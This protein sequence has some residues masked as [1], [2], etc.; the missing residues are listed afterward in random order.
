MSNKFVFFSTLGCKVNQ[1]E[2]E[3]MQKLFRAAGWEI[4]SDI[5]KADAVVV[6]TCTVTS[7]SSQKSRQI[8]RRSARANENAVLTVVGCY[9]QSEPETISKID[10]VDVIVG[11]AERMKI[12]ELIETAMRNSKLA[13][14]S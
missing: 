6:N 9:A 1:Y 7:L 12:V 3:A 2:T 14:R 5:E 10:G 11:T 13:T 4:T 8:I